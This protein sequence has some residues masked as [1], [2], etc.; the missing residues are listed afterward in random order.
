[1]KWLLRTAG[2]AV[3]AAVALLVAS[4]VSLAGYARVQSS[5]EVTLPAP[6][7]PDPVGRTV[8]DWTDTSRMDPYAA[9]RSTP[10]EL[11]VQVWYPA[12]PAPGAPTTS[13][14]PPGWDRALAGRSGVEDALNGLAHTPPGLVHPHAVEDAPL[15]GGGPFP[16]LL[17]SP[18]LGLLATDYAATAE[19]LA[20]HGYVVAGVD[21]TYSTDVVLSGGRVVPSVNRARDG[22]VYG[23]L[24]QLWAGDLRFVA[25]QL[26]TQAGTAGSRFQGRLDRCAGLSG[27]PRGGGVTLGWIRRLGQVDATER[28]QPRVQ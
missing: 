23:P 16:V 28:A 18:G 19:D 21:P 11:A 9:G 26:R 4:L 24:V 13:Y 5:R 15:A 17:L 20:S 27:D 1:V 12:R 6:A 25:G 22:A 14:L 2:L 3:V 7:G 8:F 10:R